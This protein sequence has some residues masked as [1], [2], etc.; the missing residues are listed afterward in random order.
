MNIE[1]T[2]EAWM[3]DDPSK[4]PV[5]ITLEDDKKAIVFELPDERKVW[6][7]YEEGVLRLHCYDA[8]R[9]EPLNVNIGETVV[10]DDEDYRNAF[11]EEG[12]A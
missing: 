1:T 4:T 11:D 3:S 2:L 10:V 5:T 6:L 7:E 8:V 12:A 9:A